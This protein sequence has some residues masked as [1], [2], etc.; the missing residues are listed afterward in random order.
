MIPPLYFSGR[1]GRK[2]IIVCEAVYSTNKA[3]AGRLGHILLDGDA[4]ARAN[5]SRYH[6][7]RIAYALALT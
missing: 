5:V 2:P 4:L 7:Q 6:R 3:G 1:N